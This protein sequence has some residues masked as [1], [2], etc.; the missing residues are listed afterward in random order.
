MVF[1]RYPFD[2]LW[3][4]FDEMLADMEH[5]F[6]A[7]MEGIGT[8]KALTGPGIHRRML[9]ALRGEFSVDVR[10]HEDEIVVVADLPGMEKEDIG[11]SLIDPRT[12]EI[13]SRRQKEKEEKEEG[14]YLRERIYGAVS[15]RVAL[16]ADVTDT[17]ANATYRNG[18]LELRLKKVP[19]PGEK[20]I[21]IE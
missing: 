1:R 15:R 4:D 17:G 5:Q 3:R 10:E 14:Y 7:M 13:S 9:P 21:L 11:L 8:Q 12:L 18:V 2:S 6:Q 19:R 16:P 20:Q